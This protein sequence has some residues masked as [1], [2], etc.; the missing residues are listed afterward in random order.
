MSLITETDVLQRLA[1]LPDN[2]RQEVLTDLDKRLQELTGQHTPHKEILFK[3]GAWGCY[4]DGIHVSQLLPPEKLR[5]PG[6]AKDMI[7]EFIDDDEPYED[8]K[9]YM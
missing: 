6:L 1:R 4:I 3:N 9:E 8:F 7:V 2:V 5:P